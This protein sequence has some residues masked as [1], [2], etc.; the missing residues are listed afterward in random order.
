MCCEVIASKQLQ[1]SSVIGGIPSRR[2]KRKSRMC[3]WGTK[4]RKDKITSRAFSSFKNTCHN[5]WMYSLNINPCD[6]LDFGKE[7]KRAL[8][9]KRR[10]CDVES[11]L[12]SLVPVPTHSGKEAPDS[13]CSIGTAEGSANKTHQPLGA[14]PSL[15]FL[16]RAFFCFLLGLIAH[17]IPVPCLPQLQSCHIPLALDKH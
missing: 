5:H 2:P 16:P 7:A 6:T 4:K 13:C 11:H 1:L 14:R 9:S 12:P 3:K 15:R 8:V 10:I 17:H